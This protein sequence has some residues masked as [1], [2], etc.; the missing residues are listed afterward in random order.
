MLKLKAPGPTP[1]FTEMHLIKAM[2]IIGDEVVGRKILSRKL[3][4]GEGSVRTVVS[5]LEEA[6]LIT[7][8]QDGCKLTERGR[9]IYDELRSKF[10]RMSQVE[11]SPL[12]VGTF[13]FGILVRDAAHKVRHGIEQRDAVVKAGASGATIF[14][15]KNGK[16][17]MPTISEDLMKDYPK[18]AKRIMEIF[19][20]REEDVIIFG[21][22]D[23]REQAEEG[24]RIAVWTLVNHELYDT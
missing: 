13:N 6:D 23:T 19:Q 22:A 12:T 18:V 2:E 10:P 15:Y 16:L 17:I 21:G 1:S 24:T 3:K 7:V 14:V 8:S 20:P 4:L 11:A 9:E 5:R